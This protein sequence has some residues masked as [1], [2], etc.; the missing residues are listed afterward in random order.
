MQRQVKPYIYLTV[1][2]YT[3]CPVKFFCR[4]KDFFV[5]VDIAGQNP[6]VKKHKKNKI[7]IDKHVLCRYNANVDLRNSYRRMI[8]LNCT[9]NDLCYDEVKLDYHALQETASFA[10]AALIQD[11]SDS[12]AKMQD[13]HFKAI[14]KNDGTTSLYLD[15]D[16]LSQKANALKLAADTYAAL[17]EGWTRENKTIVN[18][19]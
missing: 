16:R 19:G 5:I 7:V 15:A 12:L 17:K 4:D 6:P 9:E 2:Y 18:V 3:K 14:T 1:S 13:A 10:V 8:M 11:C